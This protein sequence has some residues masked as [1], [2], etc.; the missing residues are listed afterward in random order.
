MAWTQEEAE[1]FTKVEVGIKSNAK[2]L[3]KLDIAILG[4]DEDL[5]DFG[6]VGRVKENSDYRRKLQG[7]HSSIFKWTLGLVPTGI[8]AYVAYQ[9][10][11]WF[12]SAN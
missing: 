9:K 10:A 7:F 8:T 4:D 6:L 1:R 2:I 5:D 12:G 3:K 11:K